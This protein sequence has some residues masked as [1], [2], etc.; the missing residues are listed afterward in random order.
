MKELWK[1]LGRWCEPD[2]RYAGKLCR[3]TALGT[4]EAAVERMWGV[5]RRYFA[6][7]P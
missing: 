5:A 6:R 1:M 4:Y 7:E 3:T 2:G